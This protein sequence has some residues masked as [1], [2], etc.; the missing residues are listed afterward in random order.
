MRI[1]VSTTVL[2]GTVTVLVFLFNLGTL[3]KEGNG[4]VLRPLLFLI[5]DVSIYLCS[6]TI[7]GITVIKILLLKDG[8]TTKQ[9][10]RLIPKWYISAGVNPERA[11]KIEKNS[12]TTRDVLH[13]HFL[14]LGRCLTQRISNIKVRTFKR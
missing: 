14:S 13:K 4:Y 6:T 10:F 11:G 9:V 8:I 5:F 3:K 1:D 12:T 7:V 2:L